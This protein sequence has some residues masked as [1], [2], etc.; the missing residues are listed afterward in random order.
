MQEQSEREA[1]NVEGI[2][3]LEIQDE[4]QEDIDI[5]IDVVDEENKSSE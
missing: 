3:E 4:I 1:E 2:D 5:D